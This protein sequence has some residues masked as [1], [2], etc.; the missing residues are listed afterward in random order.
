MNGADPR[1]QADERA[2]RERCARLAASLARF[3]RL[4]I[5]FSGGVDS[6]VLLAAAHDV[7]G[8]GATAVIA[9]SPSLARSELESARATAA[10]IGAR[11][12]VVRTDELSDPG[13][14]ANAGAR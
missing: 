4:A 2:W 10:H 6:S 3:E 1:S 5:A 7:L 14:R 11:L 9:D 13:Y 8:A 12:V